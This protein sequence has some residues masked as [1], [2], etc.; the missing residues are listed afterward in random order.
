[1]SGDRPGLRALLL[2]L[3]LIGI[4]GLIAELLL[5]EHFETWTQAIPLVVLGIALAGVGAAAYHPTRS[6]IRVLRAL[7]AGFV[8]TGLAG[9]WLH[10]RGNEAFELEIAPTL[11]GTA[12]IWKT[13]RGAT[14]ILA[15]GALVQLG[16][17]GLIW[18]Y[19]HPALRGRVST[20]EEEG[21]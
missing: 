11:R 12:L 8:L 21:R 17:L 15:P 2:A 4:L 14:P 18:S 19:D 6:R 20:S 13:L 9:V 1:M 10:Y 3:V 16:L 7:M 5:M